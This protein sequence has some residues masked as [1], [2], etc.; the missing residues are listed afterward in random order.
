MGTVA[1][2]RAEESKL[3][4]RD[5]QIMRDTVTT[6][7]RPGAEVC[8][9]GEP[10]A[11]VGKDGVEYNVYDD[12]RLAVVIEACPIGTLVSTDERWAEKELDRSAPVEDV[13]AR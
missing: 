13:K 3:S 8:A 4:G 5:V 10:V 12:N 1:I 7:K 2:P 6:A 11:R 9:L